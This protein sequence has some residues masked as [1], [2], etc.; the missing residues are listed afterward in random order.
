[1]ICR[2]PSSRRS[3]ATAVEFAVVSPIVFLLLFGIVVGGMGVFRYQEVA[4][5]ARK[6]ARQASVRG[7]Q[8]RYETGNACPTEEELRQLLLDDWAVA[9]DPAKVTVQAHVVKTGGAGATVTPWDASDRAPSEVVNDRGIPVANQ[10]RVTVSYEWMPEVYL[11]GPI[12]LSS[13]AEM[14]MQY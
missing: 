9:L 14:P 8:Y 13:T 5:L 3:G 1:M 11:V 2:Y 7:G 6:A 10:V 4:W 12:T